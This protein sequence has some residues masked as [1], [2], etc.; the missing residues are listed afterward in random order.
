[1]LRPDSAV[2]VLFF[3][4]N[5]SYFMVLFMSGT[6]VFLRLIKPFRVWSAAVGKVLNPHAVDTWLDP[7]LIALV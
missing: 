6:T 1:M 2:S 7:Q 5:L 4:E 3:R